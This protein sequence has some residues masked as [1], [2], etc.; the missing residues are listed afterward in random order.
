MYPI[1]VTNK[2]S[3]SIQ[4]TPE[5]YVTT[6]KPYEQLAQSTVFHFSP[7]SSNTLSPIIYSTSDINTVKSVISSTTST[8]DMGVIV[9]RPT[10][11]NGGV[12]VIQPSPGPTSTTGSL[13]SQTGQT[14]LATTSTPQSFSCGVSRGTTNRVV[15]GNEAKKGVLFGLMTSDYK[16]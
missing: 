8:P 1:A 5:L 13:I 11:P 9:F 3:I 7:L 14:P 6:R 16:C 2:P 15:G 12:Q 4:S 10:P